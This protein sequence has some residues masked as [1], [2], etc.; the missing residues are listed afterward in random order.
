MDDHWQ[1]VNRMDCLQ[2][3]PAAA[4]AASKGTYSCTILTSVH[5][6]SCY[7]GSLSMH[8][9]AH[10]WSLPMML[11]CCLQLSNATFPPS[12]CLHMPKDIASGL[13]H[14][15]ASFSILAVACYALNPL[16]S[17]CDNMAR[18]QLLSAAVWHFSC[19]CN[20]HISEHFLAKL[21]ELA[22]PSLK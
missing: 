13:G 1:Q 22:P 6:Q 14:C 21:A 3:C 5:Q 7:I 2:D 17:W 20:Q 9:Y 11:S 8:K 18:F 16:I 10:H 15:I 4:S 12:A 19:T